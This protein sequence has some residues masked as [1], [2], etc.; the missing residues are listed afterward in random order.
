[1]VYDKDVGFSLAVTTYVRAGDAFRR[2]QGYHRGHSRFVSTER[3]LRRI[4]CA[5][6]LLEPSIIILHAP[7]DQALETVMQF[8]D[9]AVQ[10]GLPP[11]SHSQ[12]SCDDAPI[13]DSCFPKHGRTNPLVYISIASLVG[14]V[15]VMFVKGFGVA[16][17]L[18]FAGHNQFTYPST[19][20]FGFISV[21]CIVMPLDY[22]N[23]ALDIFSVNLINGF[24]ATNATNTVS[25]LCG[26]IF[27]FLGVHILNLSMLQESAAHAEA[28]G[29]VQLEGRLSLD[30][31][32][33]T[34]RD[35]AS[36]GRRA[37]LYGVR[38]PLFGD[39][40]I[41]AEGEGEDVLLHRLLEEDE[42]AV[43]HSDSRS[44]PNIRISPRP[45]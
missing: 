44:T 1:M 36:G 33:G 8:L 7:E 32:S 19:Y 43:L 12:S 39:F 25:L 20:L 34:R 21:G 27:T 14:S 29:S 3:H 6:C 45:V 23:R 15:S 38:T 17:K 13:R 30:G 18:T 26:F 16:V 24:S 22:S 10:P 11:M 4:G 9:Y 35:S 28:T 41:N 40:A 42:D 5:L 31:W 2:A 37:S